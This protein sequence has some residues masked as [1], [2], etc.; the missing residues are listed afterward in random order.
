MFTPLLSLLLAVSAQ[1]VPDTELVSWVAEAI[2]QDARSVAISPGEFMLARGRRDDLDIASE[3]T[4]RLTNA[5]VYGMV[6][7]CSDGVVVLRG[8]VRD[9]AQRA[10]AGLLAAD[11]PG[12]RS[13]KNLL[14]LRGESAVA[15]VLLRSAPRAPAGPVTTEPF[16]FHTDDK[17][18]GSGIV[19]AAVNGVI[20]LTGRVNN[21]EARLY[22]AQLAGR[23]PRVRAVRNQISVR[24]SG[25]ALDRHMASVLVLNSPKDVE[26]SVH[27]GLIILGGRVSYESQKRAIVRMALRFPAAFLVLDNI[28]VDE[29]LTGPASST[30][31]QR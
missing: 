18:A 24:Q 31:W 1:N 3:T 13:V 7:A 12:A 8:E 28:A 23:V 10:K 5:G 22:A 20:T 30:P 27:D 17:L 4:G 16:D 2:I 19:V 9:E 21:H 14:T 11:V 15:P 6:V 26:V 29:S 25:V